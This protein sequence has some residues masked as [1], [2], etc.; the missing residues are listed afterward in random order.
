MAQVVLR[1]LG[2]VEVE[3]DGRPLSGFPSKALALLGYL[4]LHPLPVPRTRLA[5]LLW[6]PLPQAQAL[7]N[8]RRVLLQLAERLPEALD[9]DA[10]AVRLR[11]GPGIWLDVDRFEDLLKEGSPAALAEAVGLYRGDFLAGLDLEESPRFQ[12]WLGAARD[13]WRR[14]ILEALDRLVQLHTDRGEEEQALAFARRSLELA[15]WREA[16]HRQVMRLLAYLGRYNAALRQYRICRRILR[17]ELDVEPAPETQALYRLI[18]TARSLPRPDLP[19]YPTPFLGREEELAHLRRLLA[20]PACR[21]ISL[22]GPGGVG[23]TRLALQ[24]ALQNQHRFLGGVRFVPVNDLPSPLFLAPALAHALA[25]PL[26]GPGPLETRLLNA[27]RAWEGLL[28]LDGFEALRGRGGELLGRIL[29]EAPGVKL[30]VTSRERLFL[31]WE[32]VVQVRGLPHPAPV[33]DEAEARRLLAEGRWTALQLFLQTARRVHPQRDLEEEAVYILALCRLLDGLPLGI[34]LAAASLD[35]T[36]C[37]ALWK[38]AARNLDV[39][40]A[41]FRDVPSRHRSLRAV[42]EGSWALLSPEEKRVFRQL[43]VFRGGFRA[44]A[45]QAVARAG[46]GV[47]LSLEAKSLLKRTERGRYELHPLVHQYAREKLAAVPAEKE[48][49]LARHQ[50]YYLTFLAEREARLE[51]LPQRAVLEEVEEEIENVRAAWRRAVDRGAVQDLDRALGALSLFYELRGWFQEGEAAFARAAVRLRGRLG[52]DRTG[53]RLRARLTIA[54]GLF[55]RYV[56]DA[57]EGEDLLLE[58]LALAREVGDR[59]AMALALNVLGILAALRGAFE[60]QERRFRESLALYQALGDRLKT[61]I[62]LNNL[63]IAA[64]IQNRYEEGERLCWESLALARELGYRRGEARAL[65]N[66]A[67]LAQTQGRYAEARRFHLQSLRAFRESGDRWGVALALGN[68]GDLAYRQGRYIQA[69]CL[70]EESLRLRRE[71]GDQWGTVLALNTLGGVLRAQGRFEEARAYLR[72]AL[73]LSRQ[74]PSLSL[75]LDILTEW[76]RLWAAEGDLERAAEVLTFILRHPAV[77][78]DTRR[79]AAAFLE[80]V[81]RSLPP[82]ALEA[83]RARGERGSLEELTGL[84][85]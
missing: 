41:P 50:S 68:L 7:G 43:S 11:R 64:R 80:E 53:R 17:Q 45:A 16:S 55:S 3:R 2:P 14:R 36:S 33:E 32:R 15:P 22:V 75:T 84:W 6:E 85:A 31:R 67:L 20:D 21:L 62:L 47:L 18:R 46:L 13:R 26:T 37:R 27:L 40:Q 71:M 4:A 63:A 49:V 29:E 65:Q 9:A 57:E 77:E 83:A 8:L 52:G 60:E 25:L 66:L 35:R 73:T 51:G 34:E 69:R 79:R 38:A 44:E 59:R 72:E 39:L 54:Q 10:H 12:V 19:G 23:K 5:A 58:G 82:A 42:F 78:D 30:L 74:I 81:A 56:G 70:L 48:R 1:L 76:A 61:A 24:A 28:I